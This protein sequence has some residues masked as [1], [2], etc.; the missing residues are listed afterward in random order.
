L[1]C[2][3][4]CINCRGNRQQN[5]SKNCEEGIAGDPGKVE[6][7]VEPGNQSI[8]REQVRRDVREVNLVFQELLFVRHEWIRVIL[9]QFSAYLHWFIKGGVYVHVTIPVDAEVSILLLLEVFKSLRKFTFKHFLLGINWKAVG[10]AGSQ[11]T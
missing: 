10:F 4:W 6:L 7:K 3:K 11:W 1:E 8:Y 5:A 9:A 2:Y